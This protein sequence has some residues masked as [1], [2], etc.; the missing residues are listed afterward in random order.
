MFWKS[1]AGSGAVT[2]FNA[3]RAFAINKLL[4]IFL[5]PAAFACV[6]QFLNLM[7][8]GQ[9]TSSLALQ[10]GWTSL[11]AQ[12]KGDSEKLLSLWHGG[13]RLT[14]FASIFTS[15]GCVL[16][17]FLAPLETLFPGMSPRLVQAA[18]LFAI[19]GIFATNIVTI[20]ASVMNG[21]G[22][23]RKWALIN[24]VTSLWQIL[25]VAFFLYSGKLSVLSIVATQSIV[26][27]LFAIQI[28]S[29]AGF[30]VRKIWASFRESRGP[31]LSFAIM[32]II[33]MIL[34]PVAL[35]SIRSLISLNFGNDA[36][37][38]WQSVWKVSDFLAMFT[39]A[40]LTVVILP[41]ISRNM[42]RVEFGK[43][44]YPMLCRVMGI[45]LVAATLL[46]VLRVPLVTIL[47]SS[48]YLG[49]VDYLPVQLIGD[50]FRA[51][52]WCLGLVLIAR[53]ETKIFIM[54]EILSQLFIVGVTF[55]G[56]KLFEFNSPMIAYAAENFL[57]FVSLFVIVRRL[58]W[59]NP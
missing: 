19:P 27:S 57:Y 5:P 1:F 35:T 42:G 58:K 56:L 51:G 45:S 15:I 3:L 50:F 2:F 59:T 34:S 33:P 48:A 44:F 14:T 30:S 20:T 8:V 23:N 41:K 7:S 46:Y 13:V 9:A 38:I 6:G 26:A 47:F 37:G 25:W 55:F 17:I 40:I 10:N 52:G 24:I 32:G 21:L 43:T 11:T 16:F 12:N 22:E 36:A 31:W 4:A 29:R 49:A 53:Q 54:A 39:S 18:I 28:A